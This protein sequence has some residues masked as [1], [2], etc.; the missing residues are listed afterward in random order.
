VISDGDI[1]EDLRPRPYHYVVAER[2][3]P[4]PLFLAGATERNALVEQAIV[5]DDGG[6]ADDDAHPVIDEEPAPD[7]SARVNLDAGHQPRYLADDARRQRHARIVQ[8]MGDAVQKDRVKAGVTEKDL[9]HAPG[10]RILPEYC[11]DLFPNGAEHRYSI[12]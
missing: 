5:S 9:Q 3:V 4:L 7:L 8:T 12:M 11:F 2:R 1:A 10:G 6:F